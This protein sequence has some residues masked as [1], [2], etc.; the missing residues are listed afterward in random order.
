MPYPRGKWKVLYEAL[1]LAAAYFGYFAVRGATE[2][3]LGSAIE[4]ARG[5]VSFEEALGIHFAAAAQRVVV[6]NRLIET[7]ANWVYAWGHWPVIGVVL[8]LLSRR[9]LPRYN[10]YRAAII[11]SGGLGVVIFSL[12][13]VAPPRLMDLGY[14]DSV[15]Q[16]SQAYRSFQPGWL[17]NQYAAF[18]S[19]HL[20]WN[21]LIGIALFR[22]WRAWP[23]RVIAVLSPVAMFAAILITA[24]HYVVDGVAGAALVL[25]GLW[26]AS[27]LEKCVEGLQARRQARAG[28]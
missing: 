23:M 13:P 3:S 18:P 28:I 14:V 12:Y 16:H 6:E 11:I 10:L 4:H 24:N 1:I 21:L 17:V 5:I 19:L 27:R 25:L 22:E 20:G 26:L 8:L 7:L 2:G 15:T 9:S